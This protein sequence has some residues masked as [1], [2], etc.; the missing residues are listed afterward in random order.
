LLDIDGLLDDDERDIAATVRK[1][2]DTRLRTNIEG[3]FESETLP[4]ELAK[5]FGDLGCWACTWTATVCAGTNA[6][7]YGLTCLELEAG[8]RGLV[9][10]ADIVVENFRAG[11]MERFGLDYETLRASKPDLIYC[12][13]TGFGRERGAA[14]PGY[15]LLVQAGGLMSVTGPGPDEP[16]KVGVALV[17]VLAGLHALVGIL[18]ALAHRHRTGQAGAL[19]DVLCASKPCA[20]R[21]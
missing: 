9:A 7:S 20:L 11:T 1:F 19:A 21:R 12:S 16:T 3:W 2:V 13:I 10:T 8:A 17:D 5:E 6:V 4:K 18:A 14:P 15:D